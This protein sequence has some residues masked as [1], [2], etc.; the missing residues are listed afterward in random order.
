MATEADLIIAILSGSYLA[1]TFPKTWM[2]MRER[3]EVQEKTD[4]QKLK[5]QLEEKFRKNKQ[6]RDKK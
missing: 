6:R 5:D 2:A 3:E 4:A 1:R